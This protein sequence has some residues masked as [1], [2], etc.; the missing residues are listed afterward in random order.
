MWFLGWLLGSYM[1][2]L[3]VSWNGGKGESGFHITK[4]ANDQKSGRSGE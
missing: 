4:G 3:V 1:T 2:L